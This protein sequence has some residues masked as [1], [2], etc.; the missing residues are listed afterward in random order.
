MDRDVKTEPY[1][2]PAGGWGSIKSVAEIIAR[3]GGARASAALVQQN[4]PEGFACVSCAWAKPADHHPAE[5]CENGAKAT[6]WELTSKT[7]GPEFFAR[8]TVSELAGWEPFELESAGRL[9]HPMRYDA[10]SD[11]YISIPWDRA[12]AEIGA[13]LRTYDPKS[14]ICYASGRASLETSYM[15]ALFARMLGTNNL[16]DSSNM[17]HETTSVA[18]PESI[19]VPVGT[20]LIDDFDAADC[21]LSFGQ[22]VGTNSPR[23]LHPL[24]NA[25]KRGVPIIVFNPLRER[26]WERFTNPQN[27][28]EMASG[29]ETR[30]ASQYHQVKA[31]GDIA[32]VVGM[33]KRLLD[34]DEEAGRTGVERVIDWAFIEEH[35]HGFD[36]YVAL[37]R[38][39]DWSDLEARS[40]ISREQM[41]EAADVYAAAKATIFVYGMGLTQHEHGAETIQTIINLM[42][43]RGNIGRPGAGL[44]PVRGHSNVQGQRT[45]GISEKPELVPLD[46][47]K[48][49]YDFEPPREEGL[50][51]VPACEAMIA[52]KIKAFIGLGGNFLYAVPETRRMEVAWRGLDL[53]VQVATKLNRTHLVPGRQTYL[54]PCLGRIEIDEQNG[55]AQAVSVEDS[56][57]CIHGSRGF[58]EPIDKH[59]LSEPRIVAGIAKAALDPNPKVD[60]DLWASNYALVR[61]AI[62]ATYPDQFTGFNERMFQPGG[63][64]RPLAARERKWNTKTGRANF[65]VPPSLTADSTPPDDDV[66]KLITVRSNDQ[67]N[68]TIYGYSDR[69]RGI[70]GTRMVILISPADIARFGLA[71]GEMVS[72]IT[73]A[74]DNVHREVGGFRVTAHDL[75][76]GCIASYFPECNPLVPLWLHDEKSKTPAGKSVPVRIKKMAPVPI[77]AE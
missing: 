11:R 14:V 25:S 55:V 26:G 67:F 53:S 61:D 72:L 64:P 2:G 30:I 56:T 41:I 46:R 7:I 13:A 8:H 3:E 48:E 21:I 34:L 24:E 62:E 49:L 68:T 47:L 69:F 28:I 75:P 54:L 76:E 4:K 29:H 63:F 71:E 37:V 58:A 5:F 59:L 40:G 1:S 66:V 36:E 73:A 9:T 39:A 27:P 60:W 77:A 74:G 6:A 16:P 19:G 38:K 52:G 70:E 35:T 12:F 31:G 50:A 33:S 32:A 57:T 10:A 65:K 20:V 17:C 18:V 44:C 23:M 45:V 43:M 51:T 22:N 15:Y 42:L